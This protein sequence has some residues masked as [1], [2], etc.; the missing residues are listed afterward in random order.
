MDIFLTVLRYAAGPV[1]GALIGYLTNW[2]AVKM[3]F[4]P[5]YPKKIGKWRLPFTP[6]IIPKRQPALAKAVGKA[7]G[8]QLFTK[9]DLAAAIVSDGAKERVAECAVN[10]WKS[11]GGKT[12]EELVKTVIPEDR[13]QPLQE[14]AENFISERIYC[15]VKDINLGG[16][17]AEEGVKAVNK[18]KS[19][20]GM[21]AMFLSDDLVST[22]AGK[23]ADG[24][25]GYVEENGKSLI[26]KSV[27][28]EFEKALNTP[29]SALTQS[30]EESVIRNAACSLYEKAVNGVFAELASDLDVCAVVERKINEMDVKELEKLVLSVM[31]K[32]LNAIV[33]IG[34]LIGFILG[35]IMIFV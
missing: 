16:V 6:G 33:N 15:A 34:A 32:E 10:L 18:M 21:L 11:A 1:I 9:E 25:N 12:A 5:H 27:K 14:K 7:V 20:L 26:S 30:V 3:L 17:V 31:K 23:L 19:S 29:L 35:V 22:I 28:A 8:E 13:Q 2:I 4:R 24:V